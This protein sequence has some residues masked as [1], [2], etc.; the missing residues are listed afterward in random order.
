MLREETAGDPITGLKWTHKTPANLSRALRRQGFPVG[1]TTVRRLPREGGY[2]L[3]VTRKR[4]SRRHDPQRDRQMR[5]I[6]RQRRAFQQAGAP[7]ISVD[8]KKEELVGNFRNAG[9]T[10]RRSP[11]AVL[12]TDFPGDADGKA[13]PYG[14]YDLQHNRGY[15]AI[16][17]SH[18]TAEGAVATIRAWWNRVGRS[19]YAGHAHLLILADGGGANS[20]R[21][22]RWKA[23]LQAL[24][25]EFSLTITVLHYPPG[26]SKW[27]PIEHRMFSPISQNWA[28]QPP[29]NYETILKFLR[30]TKTATGFRCRASLDTTDYKTGLRLAAQEIAQINV[31]PHRILPRW[32]YT[33]KPHSGGERK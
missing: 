1:R 32:N 18:E 14:V 8:T 21:S 16:G 24:A 5:S 12:A 23:G 6:A 15:L 9:R 30:T 28:G 31:G 29:V 4:L 26:A 25:D 11:L 2:A 20:D 22:R 13:L 10:W 19:R 27:N 17:T 7:M 3:R 33:I